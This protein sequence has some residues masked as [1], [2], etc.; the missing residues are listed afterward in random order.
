MGAPA[1]ASHAG[2]DSWLHLPIHS[3]MYL[4]RTPP[5]AP[6]DFRAKISR[7][8]PA[9]LRSAPA[10]H[11]LA[12]LADGAGLLPMDPAEVPNQSE[13]RCP[14]SRKREGG[15]ARLRPRSVC[16]WCRLHRVDLGG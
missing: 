11:A 16:A 10:A 5:L 1:V 13:P 2:A 4:I 7:S 6:C 9:V 15:V 8:R 3:M 12:G 14:T